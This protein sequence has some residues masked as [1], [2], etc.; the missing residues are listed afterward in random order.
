[1]SAF[2][3]YLTE[4]ELNTVNKVLADK[5]LKSIMNRLFSGFPE[6]VRGEIFTNQLDDRERYFDKE[7][8]QV[9]GGMEAVFTLNNNS[10]YRSFAYENGSVEFKLTLN[11]LLFDNGSNNAYNS[12]AMKKRFGVELEIGYLPRVIVSYKGKPV[13]MR[14]GELKQYQITEMEY[15]LFENVNNHDQKLFT[16]QRKKVY[17]PEQ[18]YEIS[19]SVNFGMVKG[20]DN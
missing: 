14:E 5:G 2:S 1:M 19:N 20:K 6:N 17:V 12:K 10:A 7:G 8:R 9:S 4:R 16:S 3:E 11:K 18:V 13:P 15:V